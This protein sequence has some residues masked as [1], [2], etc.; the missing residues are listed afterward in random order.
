MSQCVVICASIQV[1]NCVF[2]GIKNT[3]TLSLLPWQCHDIEELVPSLVFFDGMG[4][5][6]AFLDVDGSL[7]SPLDGLSLAASPLALWPL[8]CKSGHPASVL[9]TGVVGLM[10]NFRWIGAIP[11]VPH[12]GDA[13]S[14][15]IRWVAICRSSPPC[16]NVVGLAEKVAVMAGMPQKTTS[17]KGKCGFISTAYL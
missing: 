17:H 6:Q 11:A 10:A 16:R 12:V 3:Q 2:I 7:R 8:W 15:G 13:S 1:A 9:S 5:E 4:D 14:V